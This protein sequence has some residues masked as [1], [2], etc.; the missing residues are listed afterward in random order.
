MIHKINN[1]IISVK[2]QEVYLTYNYDTKEYRE[3]DIIPDDINHFYLPKA[4]S[5]KKKYIKKNNITEKEYKELL[6]EALLSYSTTLI[7]DRNDFLKSKK[8]KNKMDYFD[9][10]LQ[11]DGKTYY[12]NHRRNTRLFFKMFMKDKD[13]KLYKY[14]DYESVYYDEY[15]WYKLCYNSG[16]IHLKEAGK[17]YDTYGYDFKMS[18]PTDMCNI[19]FRIPTK[20][21]TEKTLKELPPVKYLSYGIYRVKITSNDENFKKS[22]MFS[23]N[24]GY[25]SYTLKFAM[26]MAEKLDIK[27][28]LIQDGKPNAYTYDKK[29]LISGNKL[30][31]NWYYR[32]KDLK[33]EL[34]KNSI[35]KL[36][37]SSAWGHI[38]ELRRIYKTEDEVLKMIE[39]GKRISNEGENMDYY[40]INIRDIKDRTLYEL[41][42][43]KKPVY[44]LPIRLLPFIT[45]FSRVKMGELIEKQNLYDNIIRIQTDSITLSEK[46]EHEIKGFDNFIY[47]KKISGDLEFFSINDYEKIIKEIE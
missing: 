16:L 23:P 7:C 20:K 11:V 27:I 24:N 38:N 35:V 31:G 6:K 45:G 3:Y 39:E 36:L 12:K 37:S 40:I 26:K 47:D 10:T 41:L 17:Y 1:F 21:G 46:I 19:K 8:L 32:I 18:Y 4:Y 43:V 44:E 22:F 9:N 5:Y 33:E 34:P 2:F 28:E 42:D 25:E 15:K 30:F 14:K 13:T 29:D